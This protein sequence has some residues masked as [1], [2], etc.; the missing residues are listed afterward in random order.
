MIGYVEPYPTAS[1]MA[2]LWQPIETAPKDGEPFLGTNARYA[3]SLQRCGV[4]YWDRWCWRHQVDDYGDPPATWL[5]HWM[6][7][8]APP[9]SP[10]LGQ[11][12]NSTPQDAPVLGDRAST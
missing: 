5:T 11:P 6:P 3:Y 9:Q 10:G 12:E 2:A 8:P 1:A 7:L 4:Y